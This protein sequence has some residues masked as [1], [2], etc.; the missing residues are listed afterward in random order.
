MTTKSLSW[1]LAV[2]CFVL[3]TACGGEDEKSETSGINSEYTADPEAF[4]VEFNDLNDKINA[5]LESPDKELL[6]KA[7]TTYQDYA[8][9][10]PENAD[11]PDYLLKASDFAYTLGQPEKAVKILDH[12][13]S[14]YPDY[15]RMEDVLFS[16]ASHLDFEL[17][18][19]TRAKQAYTEFINKYPDSELVKD[20]ESRIENISLSLEELAEKFMKQLEED[21]LQ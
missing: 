6:K 4:M 1:P 13:I 14:D 8:A 18:D 3:L 12:I 10:F 9:I 20:A 11:A 19:T 21:S 17:R 16:R 15:N 5:N 7:V 2:L